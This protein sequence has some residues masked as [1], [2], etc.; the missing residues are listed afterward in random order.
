KALAV[1]VVSGIIQMLFGLLKTGKLGD[2]FPSSAVHGMLAAIGIIIAA[3]QIPNAFG[4]IPEAKGAIAAI[5]EI[6][7]IITHMD[8]VI[9]LIGIISLVI[10]FGMPFIQNKWL[11]KIP[12]PLLVLFITIPLGQY[13]K[14][15]KT[16][17]VALPADLSTA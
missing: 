8:P 5:L 13:L 12:A 6:P 9:G 1:I 14:L 2:F 10:L 11:K 16:F 7:R 3:K 4:V 17:L 15:D